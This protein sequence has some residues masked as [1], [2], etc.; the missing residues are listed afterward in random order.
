L[1]DPLKIII[2]G[3]Q[4]KTENSTLGKIKSEFYPDADTAIVNTVQTND[5]QKAIKDGDCLYFFKKGNLP[6]EDELEALLFSRQPFAITGKL[7][8]ACVGIAGAGGLGTVVAENLAR[9]GIGK[10]VVAD[11]DIVEPSNLNRQRFFLD[12]IGAAKVNAL[13]DNI[14]RINPFTT[15]VPVKEKVT[16]ANC[17]RIFSGCS[18]VAECFDNPASK[19]DIVFGL[20]KSL[21][22]CAVVAASGVAGIGCGNEIKTRKISNRFYVAGDMLSDVD[23]GSGLFASRVG[24]AASMQAHIIIRLISGEE[25]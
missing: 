10:I 14:K 3:K 1:E 21:P 18:V 25:T 15:I 8:K 19:A 17:S 24:I 5:P 4:H 20:K 22:D 9:A 12:Q 23:E 16:S 2:N 11:F 13:S 7:K 6:S